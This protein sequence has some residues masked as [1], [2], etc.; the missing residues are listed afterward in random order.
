MSGHVED[1][2]ARPE[3][4]GKGAR[5]RVRYLDPDGR[6]RSRSFERKADAQRHLAQVVTDSARGT[7][8]D[9]GGARTVLRDYAETWRAAQVHRPTTRAQAETHLRRHVYPTF[10]DRP[11]GTVRRT[12]VQAWV[13]RLSESLAPATT[14]C[15]YSYLAALF[16]AAVEDRLIPATPCT[17]IA[18]PKVAPARVEP[19]G[20][21]A[22]EALADA[23]PARYG[24]LIVLAAGTGLRQGEALGL[25]VDRVDFLRRTLTVDRQL[26]LM[27]GGPPYLAPPKTPASTR[28]IPLP[29]VVVDALAAH[30]AEHPAAVQEI[31]HRDGNGVRRPCGRRWCSPRTPARRSGAPTSPAGCGARRSTRCASGRPRTTPRPWCPSGR[32]FTICATS[33]PPCL[34]PAR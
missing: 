23:V 21:E 8:L 2:W 3:R 27:P 25:T 9:P 30:L 14:R 10:G 6:E 31:E 13:T 16:R 15:V 17:R 19:L 1:R 5:W 12:E 33:T 34:F 22:V 18:L 7:Y 20:V 24:A 32:R 28:T 11:I 29:A 26:V 4:R